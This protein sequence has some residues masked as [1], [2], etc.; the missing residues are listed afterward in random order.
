MV[1]QLSHLNTTTGKAIALTIQTFVGKVMSLPFSTLYR[2][3]IAFCHSN[4]LRWAQIFL[5]YQQL[6]FREVDDWMNTWYSQDLNP[7]LS[8]Q[9][10]HFPL[11][12]CPI[13]LTILLHLSCSGLSWKHQC[14]QL[15]RASL[16]PTFGS[17][18]KAGGE[19]CS[20]ITPATGPW[21]SRS[22]ICWW[23]VVL[24][25]F[26]RLCQFVN[27]GEGQG[28]C[29]VPLNIWMC[30]PG[31]NRVTAIPG[32]LSM[33]FKFGPFGEELLDWYK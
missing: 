17:T 29:W 30:F 3:I 22:K 1:Q 14:S 13:F 7:C 24:V 33:L 10:V 21:C 16:G 25:G 31:S 19:I 4:P 12:M 11:R 27:Q 9:I 26:G 32:A 8:P 5:F 23:D 2:F 6:R 18:A 28:D 20:A 15:R